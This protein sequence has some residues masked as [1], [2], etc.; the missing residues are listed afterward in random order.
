MNF[1]LKR[2]VCMYEL[3]RPGIVQP[4]LRERERESE[5]ILDRSQRQIQT[6]K[7]RTQGGTTKRARDIS[8]Y[9]E[10]ARETKTEKD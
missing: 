6:E 1:F 7:E 2:T 8:L 5:G 3:I 10:E 9:Y 4:G